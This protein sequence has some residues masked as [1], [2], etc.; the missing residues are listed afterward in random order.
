MKQIAE[1]GNGIYG[2]CPD[3]TMVGTVF[4]N[5]LSSLISML[6][7]LAILSVNGAD[8]QLNLY[9]GSS[10][11][12]MISLDNNQS[13]KDIQINLKLPLTNQTFLVSEI[14]PLKEDDQN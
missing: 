6:S 7:P 12:L 11:N 14:A 10:T 2:Y 13:P 1:I 3:V 5:Y 9:N 4:I 8:H